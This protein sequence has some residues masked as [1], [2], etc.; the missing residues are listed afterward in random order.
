MKNMLGNLQKNDR[1]VT[2]GGIYGTV[3]NIQKDSDSITIKVDESSN[4]KLRVLR[5]AI[6]RVVTG[7]D[8]VDKNQRSNAN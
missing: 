1:I 8:A 2:I 6:S 3:V 5:S 7:D 4:A